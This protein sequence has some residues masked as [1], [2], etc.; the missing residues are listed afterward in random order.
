V[1]LLRR[2]RPHLTQRAIKSLAEPDVLQI[3]KAPVDQAR[4]EARRI[5]KEAARGEYVRVIE[6]WKQLPDGDVQFTIRIIILCA[7]H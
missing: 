2:H 7:A 6:G 4:A 1:P 5:I 3:F